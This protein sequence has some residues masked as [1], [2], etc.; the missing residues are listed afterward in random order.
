[1]LQGRF[2]QAME[3]ISLTLILGGIVAL[4]Q[5][6]SQVLYH[7]GLGIL[8]VGWLG[9][10]VF[11]HRKPVLANGAGGNPQTTID[12]RPPASVTLE[13]EP[14]VVGERPDHSTA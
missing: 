14:P 5:A 12:G 8:V 2:G 13:M 7:H 10:S 4:C 3:A 11:S 6:H 1:M 9:F